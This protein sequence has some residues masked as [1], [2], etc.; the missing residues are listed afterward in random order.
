MLSEKPEYNEK[1]KVALALAPVAFMENV[2]P[3]DEKL[4]ILNL[5]KFAKPIAVS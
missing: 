2:S 1:I 3:D 5:V 4:S